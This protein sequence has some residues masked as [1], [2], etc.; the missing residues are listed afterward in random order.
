MGNSQPGLEIVEANP[1]S[2]DAFNFSSRFCVGRSLICR[3]SASISSGVSFVAYLGI[4]PLPLAMTF[5]RSSA[6][7]PAVL[8]EMSDGPP[9]WRPSAVL[10]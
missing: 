1:Y 5:R 7:A 10:P 9:K 6:E 8:S 2:T 3:T 4:R